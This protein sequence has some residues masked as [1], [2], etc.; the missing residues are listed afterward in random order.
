M[1]APALSSY[2]YMFTDTG[3]LLNG[4]YNATYPGFVD[5]TKVTGLDVPEYEVATSELDGQHGSI[6]S[7][8]Y[9]RGRLVVVE[10]TVIS[11]P[12]NIDVFM[13][14]LAAN[15]VPTGINYP[16]YFRGAGIAQRYVLGKSISFKYEIDTSRRI[17]SATVQMQ[18]QCDDPI[19]KIN[20]APLAM[21][22]AT[23]HGVANSGLI[24]CYPI[25]T[26][27]GAYTGLSL[28]NVTTNQTLVLN[29]TSIA[30]DVTVVDFRLRSVLVNG[31]VA[32]ASLSGS[33]WNIAPGAQTIQ[34]NTTAGTPT[35][36][37]A[38]TYSGWM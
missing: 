35:S 15:F 7:V 6:T 2:Q 17:G 21:V 36:V 22:K 33:W 13:E 28:K 34:Y 27:I 9:S 10:G 14:K 38:E 4:D 24:A 26:I 3:I 37:T 11:D 32:S 19:K 16:F 29:R 12:A 18:I 30:G 8:Q 25:I 31:S 23:N 5:V 20:N 1:A